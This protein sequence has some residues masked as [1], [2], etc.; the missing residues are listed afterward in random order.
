M[1]NKIHEVKY[2][3]MTPDGVLKPSTLLQ[4]LEDIAAK[5]ADTLDFG[6]DAITANNYG[7]FLL[8]YTMEFNNYPQN[9]YEIKV[10]TEPRGANKL[11]AYRDFYITDKDDNNL[12]RVCSTWGLIDLSNKTM[13]NPIEVF[14]GKMINFEKRESDLKYNKIPAIV[15]MTNEKTFEVR[16]DDIDVNRHVN[17][18]SYIVWACETLPIDFIQGKKLQKLDINF[19]KE[20]K[21]GNSVISQVEIKDNTS[22]H[23]I[24]NQ[25]TGEELC[26]M[27]ASWI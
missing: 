25:A 14:S 27:L 12:G 8:K 22:V 5:N 17:N 7:W 13:L 10:S 15:D 6:Y 18:G 9:L 26:T 20:M 23:L 21:Y 1:F 19:K 24:K 4:Y 2:H 16:Y 3:E 11:F